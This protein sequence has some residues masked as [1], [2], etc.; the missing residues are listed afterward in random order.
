MENQKLKEALET[1]ELITKKIENDSFDTSKSL[2]EAISSLKKVKEVITASKDGI[3][4]SDIL[5]DAEYEL[6]DKLI[7]ELNRLLEAMKD[8]EKSAKN[9]EDI[10]NEV[11][12]NIF[13]PETNKS[14]NNV[15]DTET[16]IILENSDK[17]VKSDIMH[18]YI[19]PEEPA[20]KFDFSEL[21]IK[22]ETDEINDKLTSLGIYFEQSLF[23]SFSPLKDIPMGLKDVP[24][25]CLGEFH[26]IQKVI[27]SH[28]ML[29]SPNR[30][31][32]A[33]LLDERS[34]VIANAF[35]KMSEKGAE[36]SKLDFIEDF[37][38][39]NFS[40][41]DLLPEAIKDFVMPEKP[42]DLMLLAYSALNLD[43][44]KQK[45]F[46]DSN[47]L[48]SD[49]CKGMLSDIV[50]MQFFLNKFIS[51][52]KKLAPEKEN[53]INAAEKILNSSK[54]LYNNLKDE[55]ALTALCDMNMFEIDLKGINFERE[56]NIINAN[57]AIK[58]K[59]A[60]DAAILKKNIEELKQIIDSFNIKDPSVLN[61]E[62]LKNLYNMAEDKYILFMDY[63]IKANS[64]FYST[65]VYKTKVLCEVL[66][67]INKANEVLKAT[68]FD[69]TPYRQTEKTVD[70]QPDTLKEKLKISKLLTE[71]AIINSNLT[72][73]EKILFGFEGPISLDDAI[74][75]YFDNVSKGKIPAEIVIKA[76]IFEIA[77]MSTAQKAKRLHEIFLELSE[78][79][80]LLVD[81]SMFK[82]IIKSFNDKDAKY[83]F[84]HGTSDIDKI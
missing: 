7:T 9:L 50:N 54:I 60:K 76:D 81:T 51:Y 6:A 34:D 27:N 43:T 82:D 80:E 58:P 29:K 38:S 14:I 21:G 55:Y 62:K 31:Y 47:F 64:D 66:N 83:H 69:L 46:G 74:K 45:F 41:T 77:G 16:E 59:S 32:F 10:A 37:K 18:P 75:K 25:S 13:M 56:L 23:K 49:Y 72:R 63:D 73:S 52:H 68:D 2:E 42:D 3:S 5:R 26:N 84:V 40:E 78:E 8:Y 19:P 61:V 12:A 35:L 53:W 30:E 65:I 79:P 1:I 17:T 28:K 57:I 71:L 44:I 4:A 20:I 39:G 48:D 67:C 15:I 70:D 22:M 11:K 33:N 24:A 36:I